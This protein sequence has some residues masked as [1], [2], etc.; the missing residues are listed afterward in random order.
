MAA[1]APQTQYRQEFVLAF[2][3]RQ[4]LLKDTTTKEAVIKGNTATFLV[5]D[6]AGTAVT[7]GANGLIPSGENSNTQ[8]SAT[9]AEKHDLREMTGFNIFQSQADQRSIMQI[10]TM[11][12]INRDI[13]SVIIAALDDTSLDTGGAATASLTMIGKAI[14]QMQINGVPWD[15]NV[16]AIISPSFLIYLMAIDTFS[17]ADFVN[18]KP[19]VNF[20]GWDAADA[21]KAGQGWYEWLGVKWIVSNQVTGVGTSSETCIMYHRSAVGHAVDTGGIDSAIGYDPKHQMSWA[22]CSLF[23]GAVLL[24]NAGSVRMIHDGSAH[25]AT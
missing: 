16:F 21:K 14:A 23:H 4:S 9:L 20:P 2:G 11:S 6:S 7:R 1:A 19:A 25:T 22:R 8:T 10:N 15:G 3:Q 12:V 13:D 24:Q 5:T 17:S 18:V